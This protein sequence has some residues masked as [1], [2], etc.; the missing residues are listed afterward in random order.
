VLSGSQIPSKYVPVPQ[1]EELE[2]GKHSVLPR[3]EQGELMYCPSRQDEQGEQEIS[4]TADPNEEINCPDG[5]DVESGE[6]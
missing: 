3:D 5:Q 6:H 4:D 2:Q 1:S